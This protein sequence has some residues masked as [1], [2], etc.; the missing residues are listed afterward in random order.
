VKEV[1]Q[2]PFWLDPQDPDALF[3]PVEYALREP[4]GLL[5]IGG[6]LSPARLLRAYRQ[7]IFPWYSAGQPILWWSPDPRAVLFP[8]EVHVSRSL[9]KTLR[10]ARFQVSLDRAFARVIDACAGPRAGADGTWITGEMQ[11]AYGELH[12]LGHAHSVEAWHGEHLVGGLYGLAIGRAFFGESMFSLAADA[13]KV[14]FIHLVRQLQEWGFALIDCQVQT[15][16]LA[17]FGARPI[18]R[19]EFLSLLARAGTEP[20]Q[21]APWQL[22][23]ALVMALRQ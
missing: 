5:A 15:R 6:D 13:S 3:P 7:G 2:G 11:A 4:D 17:R 12:R 14:A 8:S 19:A 18:P 1:L 10:K 21:P 20:G 22:D 23:P 9:H 16:H